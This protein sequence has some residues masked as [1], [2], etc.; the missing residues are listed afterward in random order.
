MLEL[1]NP[2]GFVL[3]QLRSQLVQ[4]GTDWRREIVRSVGTWPLA[5]EK[6]DG[7]ELSYLV[8]GE[9]FNWKKLAYRVGGAFPTLLPVESVQEWL[10]IPDPYGGLLEEEFARLL[11]TEK[12]R[13][14]LNYHYGITVERAL[15]VAVE[16]EKCKQTTSRS[17]F[18]S[19]EVSESVFPEL[20][21]HSKEKLWRE[22]IS[23]IGNV[24]DKSGFLSLDILDEF[25]YWLFKFRATV[26]DPARLASDTKKGLAE[27]EKM[28]EQHCK[29]V[30]TS[31]WE[32]EAI[33]SWDSRLLLMI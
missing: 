32:G 9:A 14:H 10:M 3:N 23:A 25:T 11:G 30:A 29:R 18:L 8:G 15:Q 20:Y 24:C 2:V 22:F 27:L 16:R 12:F 21:S 28:V 7:L 33:A 31:A 19:D 1:E 4:S 5:H 26:S 6:V 13:A 17:L